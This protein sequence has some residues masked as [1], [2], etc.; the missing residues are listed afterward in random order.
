MS[1]PFRAEVNLSAVRHNVATVR[2]ATTAQVMA[3]IKADAYGHGAVG[4]ARAAVEAGATW[5]GVAQVAEAV[6]FARLAPEA[7]IFS[8]MY[9]PATDLAPAIE[10]G[11]DL[12]A[13]SVRAVRHV[14]EAADRAGRRARVHLAL[15]TGMAREGVRP[16][17]WEGLVREALALPGLDVV[18]MWS[19][20]ARADEPDED[21][22]ARQAELFAQAA[23]TA[24]RLGAPLEV[25]HLA[26][27]AGALWHSDTHHD[28]VRAGIAVYGLAPDGSD[29]AALGLRPAMRLI[30]QVASVREVP[31]GTPVS[32][33]GTAVVGP[34]RLGTVPVGY[35]DGLPRQA[36][37]AGI[38]VGVAGARATVVGR[39]CMDQFVIDLGGTGAE[40]GDEVTVWGPGGPSVDE[41]ARAAGTINYTITTQLA[42]RVPRVH[43]E[44]P[45]N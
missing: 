9:T 16:E 35:A 12:S 3:V 28:L 5:L 31:A 29:P 22:T 44:E 40:P 34:T 2:G 20:L 21:A 38:A 15:D 7:R 26:N 17:H 8:W 30:S 36:S 32:Y 24:E 45:W 25:R 14:A 10:A 39:I 1:F 23:A 43:V 19:H 27:S 11:I 13:G 6:P 41:W 4:V 33:G 42:A 18:G 37:G